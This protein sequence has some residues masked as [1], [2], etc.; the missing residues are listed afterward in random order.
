MHR[1]VAAVEVS[2]SFKGIF[3]WQK[4]NIRARF[5]GQ[6]QLSIF[7]STRLAP[8]Q[9]FQASIH[10]PPAPFPPPRPAP[11]MTTT[12][13]RG[14]HEN[15]FNAVENW[16]KR[17]KETYWWRASCMGRAVDL[18]RDWCNYCF[19]AAPATPSRALRHVI[20]IFMPCLTVSQLSLHH[21]S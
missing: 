15:Q 3:D 5:T 11:T 7:T 19:A 13:Q 6:L 12:L 8:P 1:T 10:P 9:T 17:E 2:F 16:W 14:G 20:C 4:W 18:G 21:V